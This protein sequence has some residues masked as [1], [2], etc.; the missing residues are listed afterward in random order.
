[1]VERGEEIVRVDR[2]S[3]RVSFCRN[4]DG[5]P[6]CILAAEE[7]A[8]WSA[9]VEALEKR[10]AELEANSS[11]APSSKSNDDLDKALETA[12]TMMR[13]FFDMMQ[14]LKKDMQSQ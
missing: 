11:G 5:G 14:T 13:R 10:V 7:R 2:E 9:E 1:M 6:V 3:G 8:A 4:A 12:E